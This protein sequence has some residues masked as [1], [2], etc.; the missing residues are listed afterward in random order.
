MK[1]CSDPIWS[2]NADVI[3]L[4]GWFFSSELLYVPILRTILPCLTFQVSILC[5]MR[6]WSPQKTL[7]IR[8]LQRAFKT[9][10]RRNC[11][12]SLN[13]HANSN[14]K[15]ILQAHFNMIKSRAHWVK[16]FY[17][18]TLPTLRFRVRNSEKIRKNLQTL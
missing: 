1:F 9:W 2:L 14:H 4:S 3:H 15:Q 8:V 18:G 7:K 5:M 16:I 6:K 13:A 17:E 11:R 10:L 12:R